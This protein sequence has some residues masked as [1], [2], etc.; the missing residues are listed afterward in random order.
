MCRSLLQES[1][2]PGFT[3]AA[4]AQAGGTVARLV[5]VALISAVAV[6]TLESGAGI[7]VSR[8]ST[9]MAY[10]LWTS[11][12]ASL[13]L[14]TIAM[15]DVVSPAADHPVLDGWQCTMLPLFLLANM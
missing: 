4:A 15:V 12:C 6:F 9:N 14:A 5:G 8:R 11:S 13:L 7:A 2:R 3:G 1:P 10:V